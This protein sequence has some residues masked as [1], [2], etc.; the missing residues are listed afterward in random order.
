VTEGHDRVRRQDVL[1]ATDDVIEIAAE[2]ADWYDRS[3]RDHDLGSGDRDA[4]L[5]A[6]SEAVTK[7]RRAANAS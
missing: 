7:L 5:K 6:L 4:T 1:Q 3:H 2:L